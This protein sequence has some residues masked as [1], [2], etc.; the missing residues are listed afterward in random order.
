[1]GYDCGPSGELMGTLCLLQ[2]GCTGE[3]FE[4]YLKRELRNDAERRELERRV[5]EILRLV[6]GP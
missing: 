4:A 5:T 3:D 1:M 2:N 6:E